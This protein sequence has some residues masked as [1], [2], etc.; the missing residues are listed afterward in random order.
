MGGGGWAETTIEG[1]RGMPLTKEVWGWA[2]YESA[3][4]CVCVCACACAYFNG[5]AVL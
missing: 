1:V 5:L 4:V 3:H 2:E